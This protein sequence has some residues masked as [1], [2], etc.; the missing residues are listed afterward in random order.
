MVVV[1]TQMSLRCVICLFVCLMGGG[2]VCRSTTCSGQMCSCRWAVRDRESTCGQICT[3][4]Q[5]QHGLEFFWE[6]LISNYYSVHFLGSAHFS[7]SMSYERSGV[8]AISVRINLEINQGCKNVFGL[9]T[10]HTHTRARARIPQQ[11]IEKG[12]ENALLC[13]CELSG[14]GNALLPA[15]RKETC[16]FVVFFLKPAITEES[17]RAAGWRAM[18]AHHVLLR[19]EEVA[20]RT[21]TTRRVQ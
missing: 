19:A 1:V 14:W 2:Y 10:T 17:K 18:T 6:F 3:W 13:T 15:E 21:A 11:R 8:W 12:T 16:G 7:V 4:T 5:V 20:K 9:Q